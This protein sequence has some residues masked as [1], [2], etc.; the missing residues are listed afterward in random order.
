MLGLADRGR[1]KPGL[2]A[3][4]MRFRLAG[5]TPVVRVVTVRGQ[6]VF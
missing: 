6:R 3:D 2:R 5:G 1:L 4:F